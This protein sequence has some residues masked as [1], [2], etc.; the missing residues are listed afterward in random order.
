[1]NIR[2]VAFLLLLGFFLLPG[3]LRLGAQDKT[4]PYVGH[5][6]D[7]D[8]YGN[9]YILNTEKNAIYMIDDRGRLVRELGGAGWGNEQFDLPGPA[10]RSNVELC[11]D[12]RNQG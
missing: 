9:L 6:L 10:L 4:L 8:I 2:C 3:P 12:L 1:M 7:V 5:G 11:F